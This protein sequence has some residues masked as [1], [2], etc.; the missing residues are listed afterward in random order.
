METLRQD[1]ALAVRFLKK[2]PGFT[3]PAVLTLALGIGAN[4]T[5]FSLTDAL[6]FQPLRVPDGDRLVHVFQRR[7][8]RP[9]E[10]YGLALPD[11]FDYRENAGGFE[12]LAAHYPTSP[13]HIVID[14][15]PVSANG[16]VATASYFDVLQLRPALGRF[17]TPEED[18]VRDR[19]AVAVISHGFW[20]RHFGGR[21]EAVGAVLQINGRIFTVVGVA[22]R[23]FTGVRPRA[24]ETDAWIPSAMFTNGYRYCD[25]FARGCT[26]VQMLGRVRPGVTVAAV[27]SELDVL[28][29]GLASAYPAT[30]ADLGLN[31]VPARGLGLGEMSDDIRQLRLFLAVVGL[32]LL[33]AC[34]NVAGLLMARAAARRKELAMRLALGAT[35]GRLIR[36][37]LTETAVLAV[38]GSIAGLLVGA[39]GNALLESVYSHD[40]GGRPASFP[41]AIS[42]NVFAATAAITVGAAF[43]VGIIPS[44]VAGR[45]D[46][47]TALKDEG[48]SGGGRRS[49][50]RQI[51]VTGQVAA[52]VVLLVGAALLL[53]SVW[54][55]NR[56]ANFDPDHVAVLRLRPSLV[57][58]PRERAHRFQRQAI[59]A[60]EALPGVT[61]A[62][63]SVFFGLLGGG[64]VAGY[65]TDPAA[66]PESR[67]TIL[68]GNAG[69][70]YFSTIGV[71]LVEGRDFT[72]RDTLDAPR[73]VV[74]NDVV[75]AQLWP[76]Q[77]AVGETLYVNGLPHTVVGVARDAQYYAAGQAPRPQIF[78]SYWQP[79][80]DDAFA[81]DSRMF[82]RTAGDPAPLMDA[83]RKAIAAVD[84]DVPISEDL[85]LRDRIHYNY[86]PV[87]FART[88]MV[89]FAALAL[90]LSAVGIYGVL[91]F[92]VAQRTRELAI[93]FALG[94]TRS[95]VARLVLRDGVVMTVIGVTVG[96]AA[97]WSSS[98]YIASFLYGIQPDAALA[99]LIGPVLIA[100]VSLAASY[101]PA[102]RAAGVSASAALRCE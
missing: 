60:I 83:I 5:I 25:A 66:S 57:D 31:V 58:Y 69:A 11:Y 1:L 48:G 93:R 67:H 72:D 15:E 40:A 100:V 90:V 49:R 50:A 33:I 91:A 70:D 3:L 2:T 43:L 64:S 88:M 82:V 27:Q 20:Q 23:G 21:P 61:S 71:A 36:Q 16:A 12:A 37:L 26:I 46:V 94:A 80:G 52:S 18:Q 14:G 87:R 22:P 76:S 30:N 38:L 13:M 73:V 78:A 29:A 7:P 84:P 8:N 85:P 35:R 17:F 10:P 97:A 65:S 63:P 96:L 44:L 86:Q 98:R 4:T 102:R 56:G 74:V 75:A 53:Q 24:S 68:L 42:A 32:V 101:A 77:R 92:S 34:A 81:N 47:I 79:L 19:D 89:G 99:Y 55:L 95:S 6:L 41:L 28:A 39:W 45:A 9:A 59:E 54:N 51:L 62:S